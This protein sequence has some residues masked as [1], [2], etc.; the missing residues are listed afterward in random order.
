MKYK[1]ASAL[2]LT[3]LCAGPALCGTIS[4]AGGG[5]LGTSHPFGGVTAYGFNDSGSKNLFGKGTSGL[6]GSEDGLGIS[7]QKDD[8]IAGTTFVQLDLTSITNPFSL[9]IGSTQKTEGFELCFSS[10]LGTEGTACTSYPTPGSDPFS[11]ALLTKSARY[12]SIEA[13]G[14]GNVLVNSLTTSTTPEPSSLVLLGTGIVG[15][16]GFIRRKFAV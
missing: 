14:E 12:I 11:T 13:L 7:G 3:S 2:I 5:N 16:A 6:F 8:E 9:L 1:L 15:A 4:F 10:I